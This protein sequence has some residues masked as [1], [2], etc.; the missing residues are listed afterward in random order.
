MITVTMI[1]TTVIDY[2]YGVIGNDSVF[3]HGHE[4]KNQNYIIDGEA[5]I[6]EHLEGIIM[7]FVVTKV[8]SFAFCDQVVNNCNNGY[9]YFSDVWTGSDQGSLFV[10]TLLHYI[11]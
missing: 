10:S 7:V 11:Y 6:G 9:N 1:V 5:I 4:C 3:D 2:F 8:L